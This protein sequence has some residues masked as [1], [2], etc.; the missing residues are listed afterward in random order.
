MK[1]IL[2]T[3]AAVLCCAMISTVFTACGDD[4]NES[5]SD[6]AA[7]GVKV[8]TGSSINSNCDEVVEQMRD[9]LD[10]KWKGR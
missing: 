1:K 2:M 3:L 4:E 8:Y 6:Y 10:K 7:Y 5:I 9:A